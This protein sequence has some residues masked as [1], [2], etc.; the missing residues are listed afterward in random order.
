VITL[1]P[2]RQANV[3]IDQV[4]HARLIKYGLSPIIFNP[5]FT[6]ATTLG[7]AGASRWPASGIIDPPHGSNNTQ[8]AA[9]KPVDVF[10][11]AMFAAEVFAG[12]I[13]FEEREYETA[14]LRIPRGGNPEM[15]SDAQE[16]GPTSRMWKFLEWCWQ[17]SPRERPT[18]EQVVRIGRISSEPTGA[19]RDLHTN[20]IS[21]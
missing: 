17:Q 15:P 13:P 7:L 3:I 11:F 6:V 9:S 14:I 1:I 18:M 5:R 2:W 16:V 10:A 8:V 4:G 19:C 20:R 12:K 21:V